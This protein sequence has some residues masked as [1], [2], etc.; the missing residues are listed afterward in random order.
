NQ[1]LLMIAAS[2]AEPVTRMEHVPLDGWEKLSDN[3]LDFVVYASVVAIISAIVCCLWRLVR[4][5]TLV[6]RGIASDTIAIQVVA[7]VILLTIV[8]RSLA[9]FDAVLIVSIL[10]FAG[11]VAF[12]QFLGRRGSVQ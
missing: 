4:G 6:D 11:T 10:G 7:L 9:L 2:G 3:I 5:P 1:L 12:A 8:S